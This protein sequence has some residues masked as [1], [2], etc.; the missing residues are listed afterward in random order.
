MNMAAR[1]VK[2]Y[3]VPDQEFSKQMKKFDFALAMIEQLRGGMI[4]R[5]QSNEIKRVIAGLF[6]GMPYVGYSVGAP[7]RFFRGRI[8][9]TSKLLD[10]PS[11]FGYRQPDSVKDYGRCHSP[12]TSIF[13]CSSTLETVITELGPEVG[14][15]IHVGM[16]SAKEKS[17]IH[18]TA[19]GEIDYARRYNRP[20]IGNQEAYKALNK[21][22]VQINRQ[23][24]EHHNR[25]LVIDAFFSDLFALPARKQ[26]EYRPTS[27]L[28]TLLFQGIA[29]L[30]G[31][32]YPSVEHRGGVN[33]A[34][35][36][37]S[38]DEKMEWVEFRTLEVVE[39]VGFGIYGTKIYATA[40]ETD[41]DGKLIWKKT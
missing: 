39:Y 37:K 10:K 15:R 18:L 7:E 4:R 13:Y 5:L 14:D 16:A 23:D 20:V 36:P 31:F 22:L 19:I 40:S 6:E 32:G 24:P 21:V 25:V 27:A 29:G 34:I 9:N 30:D 8:C 33:Y 38:F 3:V 35:L 2:E 17:E 26:H 1:I 11:E 12:G 28:S 41:E